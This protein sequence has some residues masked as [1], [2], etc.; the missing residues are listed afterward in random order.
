MHTSLGMNAASAHALAR[1]SFTST[2]IG[3]VGRRQRLG[4]LR[5]VV[6]AIA[7]FGLLGAAL[8]AVV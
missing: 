1:P 3:A 5:N 6:Q 8:W 7:V 2:I 4:E